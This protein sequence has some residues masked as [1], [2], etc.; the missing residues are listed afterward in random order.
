MRTHL[1]VS[2]EVVTQVS[3]IP[4]LQATGAQLRSIICAALI[5]SSSM[6]CW[7]KKP[8]APRRGW[9]LPG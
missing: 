6:V 2:A 9:P 8:P 4:G 7:R 1:G 5:G 3:R